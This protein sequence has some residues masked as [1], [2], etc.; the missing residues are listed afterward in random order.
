[1]LDDGD[2]TPKTIL[3]QKPDK[4]TNMFTNYST[5]LFAMYLY[6]IGIF[7]FFLFKV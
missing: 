1:M 4:N 7:I 2:I 3:V 5:S 6:F